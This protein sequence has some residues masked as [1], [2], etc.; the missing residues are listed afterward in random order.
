MATDSDFVR[1]LTKYSYGAVNGTVYGFS[2]R[3]KA[4]LEALLCSVRL[5]ELEELLDSIDNN[6]SSFCP[7]DRHIIFL[8]KMVKER[9]EAVYEDITYSFSGC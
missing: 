8:R 3:C 7:D 9:L 6:A 2:T 4:E 1:E 5:F